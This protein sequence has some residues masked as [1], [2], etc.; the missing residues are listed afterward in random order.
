MKQ[1]TLL[2]FAQL[3]EQAGD[4]EIAFRTEAATVKEL[5]GEVSTVL[6]LTMPWENLKAARNDAFCQGECAVSDGDT[7]SF[8]PPMSGG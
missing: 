2:F 7:I 4:G 6:G 8:M 5:Y 3:K 1:V